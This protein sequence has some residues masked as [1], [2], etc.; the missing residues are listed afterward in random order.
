MPFS[1]RFPAGGPSAVRERILPTIVWADRL[2]RFCARWGIPAALIFVLLSGPLLPSL[3]G[4][5]SPYAGLRSLHVLAGLGL[6]L[7]AVYRLTLWSGAS[8]AHLWARARRHVRLAPLPHQTARDVMAGIHGV[9]LIFMLWTG[10]ERYAGQRWGISLW[11]ILTP[12]EWALL[13]RLLAPYYLS[14][15]LI[16]WFMRSRVAWRRLLDQLRRP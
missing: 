9:L 5:L 7:A 8:L 14:A 1:D 10:L 6:I 16:Y 2:L 13:H 15:L 3:G 4:G 11:P 12:T